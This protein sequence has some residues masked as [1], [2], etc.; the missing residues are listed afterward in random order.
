MMIIGSTFRMTLIALGG[1]LG[2]TLGVAGL[3][4]A[5]F[6]LAAEEDAPVH[7]RRTMTISATGIVAGQPDVATVNVGVLTQA[8][9]AD[10]ALSKNNQDMSKLFATLVRVGIEKKDVQT[11]QFNVNPNYAKSVSS[12]YS[13]RGKIVGYSVTN[14]VRI[15]VRDLDR[16][17]SVLDQLSK[18]GANQMHGISFGFSNP[19]PLQDKAGIA[20]ILEARRKAELYA[21]AAGVT[22]GAVLSIDEQF[23][24]SPRGMQKMAMMESGSTVPIAVGESQIT[25]GVSITFELK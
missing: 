24:G 4:G 2:I 6:A 25:A 12:S 17:G 7:S 18:N 22:L 9:T 15:M 14:Q 13:S 8:E 16:L 20:A 5:P 10:E 21:E 23:G 11:S 19:V 1:V 3:P